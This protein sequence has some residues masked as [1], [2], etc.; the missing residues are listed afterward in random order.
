[1]FKLIFQEFLKIKLKK[2]Y[3]NML[4]LSGWLFS[5]P[6]RLLLIRVQVTGHFS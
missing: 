6:K 4:S 3:L 5:V 2:A 1:M